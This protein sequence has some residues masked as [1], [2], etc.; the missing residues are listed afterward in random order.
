M[1]QRHCNHPTDGYIFTHTSS[2]TFSFAFKRSSTSSLNLEKYAKNTH[3]IISGIGILHMPSVILFNV[4]SKEAR[5]LKSF[6]HFDVPGLVEKL[7]LML[8]CGTCFKTKQSQAY[9][10]NGKLLLKYFFHRICY[11]AELKPLQQSF[12]F[13]SKHSRCVHD[14]PFEVHVYMLGQLFSSIF[15]IFFSIHFTCALYI[16]LVSLFGFLPWYC[17]SQE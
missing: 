3:W 4:K 10:L 2:L 1:L 7:S 16:L 5:L 6:E 8:R 9:P 15:S 17:L 13:P 12:S 11:L 14:L